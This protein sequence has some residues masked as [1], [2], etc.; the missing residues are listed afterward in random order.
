VLFAALALGDPR[1][2]PLFEA[3]LG[4]GA[5]PDPEILT[6]AQLRAEIGAAFQAAFLTIAAFAASGMVLAW[7]IPA[8][9]L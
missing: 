8:R 7:W 1:A 9:R 6:S 4:R 2:L 5:L 3:L